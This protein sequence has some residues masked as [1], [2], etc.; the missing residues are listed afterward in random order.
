MQPNMNDN[1]NDKMNDNLNDKKT[2]TK[3]IASLTTSL[4]TAFKP[5]AQLILSFTLLLTSSFF[6]TSSFAAEPNGGVI[7]IRAAVNTALS[8]NPSIQKAKEVLNYDI[9]ETSLIRT[10]LYPTLNFTTT[11]LYK[12][13]SPLA[14]YTANFGGEGYNSYNLDLKLNQPLFAY[15]SLAAVTNSDYNRKINQIDVELAE[16]DLTNQ[17]IQAFYQ[18]I[19][20]HKI[21]DLLN[22]QLDVLQETLKTS[23]NR[24]QTGR[25][26][27]LDVLQVKTQMALLKPQIIT[28]KN[29]IDSAA[30]K[31]STLMG[32]VSQN[33]AKI[34]GRL[35]RIPRA[36]IDATVNL[37]HSSLPELERIRMQRLQL[38]ELKDVTW[39]KHYP[40]L[41]LVGDLGSNS[42]T[43][44]EIFSNY[45]QFWSVGLQLTIPI[46]S[47]FS[48][49]YEQKALS[50]Q[51]YQLEYQARD[52]IAN[53]ELSQLTARKTLESSD[54]SLSSA[55]EASNLARESV[56]EAKRNYRLATI[57]F[58]IFLS[59]QNSQLTADTSFFNTEYGSIQA[60]TNYFI[61]SGQSL[62]KL[63]DL[64]G[65]N[66]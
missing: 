63:I 50:S 2:Q 58:L 36:V 47:G 29:S 4:T 61:A 49:S 35:V 48:S 62:S 46:F 41:A 59:V 9:A 43:K 20:D 56:A 44:S 34:K 26:Q 33:E 6:L 37:K 54:A 27:L 1:M 57:D 38:N 42:Y 52:T 28:A 11:G 39:G 12:K 13:D 32:E 64:L 30:A 31:L 3:S 17:V 8:N 22:R 60:I 25:G 18:V 45:S 15:G 66:Q 7:T 51:D 53:L 16:R 65:E 10:S 55:E 23:Q 5:R 24:Y 14:D 40:N 21:L 19:L